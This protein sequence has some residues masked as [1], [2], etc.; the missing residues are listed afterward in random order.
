MASTG[1]TWFGIDNTY[2]LAR[3]AIRTILTKTDCWL[4]QGSTVS[5][6]PFFNSNKLQVAMTVRRL[7]WQYTY[8]EKIDE[9]VSL[10]AMCDTRLC[11]RPSHI[12][13]P[14]QTVYYN[15][16]RKKRFRQQRRL[17]TQATPL[18]LAINAAKQR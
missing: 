3:H 2:R 14:S 5:G 18:E 15:Q 9:G 13:I 6:C 11:V 1:H 4:W 16:Q 8:N 10:K 17:L 7:I 12:Y